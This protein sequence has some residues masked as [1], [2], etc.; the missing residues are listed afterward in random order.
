MDED[1]VWKVKSLDRG[2]MSMIENVRE[3]PHAFLRRHGN[4]TST[5]DRYREVV[6]MTFKISANGKG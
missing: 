5:V 6:T 4:T 1:L 2:K 3:E